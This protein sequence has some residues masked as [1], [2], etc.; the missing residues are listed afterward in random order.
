MAQWKQYLTRYFYQ[1]KSV[2]LAGVWKIALSLELEQHQRQRV[3][4]Q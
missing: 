1:A 2:G 3:G 4:E